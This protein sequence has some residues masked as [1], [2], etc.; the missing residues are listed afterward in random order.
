MRTERRKGGLAGRA[1]PIVAACMLVAAVA[2]VAAGSAATRAAP[3]SVA[4]KDDSF[5]TSVP[6]AILI[7]PDS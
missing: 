5:Q 4:K 7:D 2:I 3:S 6:N 1:L